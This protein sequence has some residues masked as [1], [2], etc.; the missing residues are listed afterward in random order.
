MNNEPDYSPTFYR[1]HAQRYA[2]VSHGLL[3]STYISSSHPGLKDDL[4]LMSRL[5]ELVPAGAKGLDAGCGAGA[6]DVFYYWRDGYDVLG[7]DFVEENIA[8]ARELHPEIAERVAVADLARSL[9]FADGAFDFVLCN[10]VIQHIAA[11]SVY[12]TTLPEL[13]RVLKEGGALQLMFKTGRGVKTVYDKDYKADRT[14]H[15]YSA[16]EI[17]EAL[18][19]L[20]ME[21]IPVERDGLGGV[22]FFTDPKPMDHCVFFSRKKG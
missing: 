11:E 1:R 4:D 9:S 7:V 13:V 10:A 15:L 6:R 21:V 22:M 18:G 2:E 16:D 17:V 14:F 12:E 8:L 20:G 3:Q 19:H 5:K